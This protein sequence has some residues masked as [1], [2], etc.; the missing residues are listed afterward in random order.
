[1]KKAIL[2]VSFGTSYKETRQ[3]TIEACEKKIQTTFSDYKLYSAYTSDKIIQKISMREGIEVQN[4]IQALEQ[5]HEEQY[6]EVII[7][8]LYIIN[9]KEFDELAK[10]VHT[11]QTKFKNIFLG[12]PLL[13]PKQNYDEVV[14]A[15][16]Y[17]LP[18]VNANEA[19]VFMGHGT[20]KNS[21]E[22]YKRLESH[23]KAQ[24]IN[25]YIATIEGES[26]LYEVT[27][28]LQLTDTTTIHLVPLMLV[29]GYHVVKDMIGESASSWKNILE[30]EGFKVKVD[31]K[32]LGENPKIQDL[33]VQSAFNVINILM[34]K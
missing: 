29:A 13:S 16:K 6:E 9:G 31:L 24:G 1:M 2:V 19:I 30:R 12:E 17:Q 28:K 27:Q 18:V 33:F 26:S 10:Q 34:D 8:P 3:K 21:N 7:Q 22:C 15:I 11:Y 4:P 32:A 25:A 23:L 20:L 14:K 5:L